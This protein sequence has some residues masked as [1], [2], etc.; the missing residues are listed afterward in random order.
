MNMQDLEERLAEQSPALV[1]YADAIV[2]KLT[3]AIR[4]TRG[5]AR[6]LSPVDIEAGGL[7]SA[8]LA[9]V[10]SSQEIFS[11]SCRLELDHEQPVLSDHAATQLYCI[12]NAAKHGQAKTIHVSLRNLPGKGLLLRV[13]NDGL[14]LV[15]PKDSSTGMGL[16]I[17]R[18]RA[19]SIGATLE[20][21]H[22]A[23]DASLAVLCLMPETAADTAP[24]PPITHP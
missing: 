21:D 1:D 12:A 6:G 15:L 3:D 14:P 19:E 7:G 10:R 13:S 11:V 5:L 9:L 4:I 2:E 24:S 20:F 17:M 8:L 18:Y 22:R 16:P 23:V